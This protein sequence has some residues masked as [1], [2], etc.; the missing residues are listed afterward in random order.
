MVY[1]SITSKGE[2]PKMLNLTDTEK[3][4]VVKAIREEKALVARLTEEYREMV[5]EYR[6]KGYRAP[7]CI[8]GTNLWVE[9]DPICHYCEDYGL[10][11]FDP[12]GPY[13]AALGELRRARRA[14]AA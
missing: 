14:L 5:E 1:S 8:H 11:E 2:E 10:N 3:A 12:H 6:A 9:Y 4:L 13:W 7:R